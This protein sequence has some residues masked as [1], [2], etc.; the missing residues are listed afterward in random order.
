MEWNVLKDDC[1]LSWVRALHLCLVKISNVF[2][3]KFL[4]T[5]VTNHYVS[6]H[7]Y[8]SQFNTTD[9]WVLV[10]NQPQYS[11]SNFKKAK[12]STI[13]QQR[14]Y[15][16]DLGHICLLQNKQ[17][18]SHLLLSWRALLFLHIQSC[19]WLFPIPHPS[20]KS[21][22][23]FPS[24]PSQPNFWMASSILAVFISSISP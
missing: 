4:K 10:V 16:N 5:E 8:A 6:G 15:M 11:C 13:H 1:H 7:S 9:W 12:N 19:P 18:C 23:L 20:S 22:Q 17:C 2:V 3:P 14:C 21:P 24:S